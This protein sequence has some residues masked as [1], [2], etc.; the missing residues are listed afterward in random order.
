MDQADFKHLDRE[1]MEPAIDAHSY[2]GLRMSVDFRIFERLAIFV[3]G[4]AM[5]KRDHRKASGLWRKETVTV[6]VLPS[7]RD[8]PQAAQAQARMPP[9][10]DTEKVYLQVF[11]DIPKQDLCMLLPGARVRMSKMDRGKIG[12]PMLS[13]LAIAV[14]NIFQNIANDLLKLVAAWQE[15]AALW[16]IASGAVGYGVRSYYG[17]HQ[18]RQAY[19]LNLTRV[20]YFQ[21]LDTNSGVLFRLLDEAEEQECRETILAYYFLWRYAGERGWTARDLDDYIEIDL[22]R[23]CSLKVDFDID[24][25]LIR[26]ERMRIVEKVGD[27]HR[28]QPDCPG[29]ANAGFYLGQLFQV[30]Q[31]GAGRSAR[32]RPNR[33]RH[34]ERSLDSRPHGFDRGF[35]HPQGVRAGSEP[36]GPRQPQHRPAAFRCA[37][38][39]QARR[40]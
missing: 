26:L 3:R 6:P 10:V 23:R 8:D 33:K 7:G 13:G 1:E 22:E 5:Q 15:P 17:Y 18:T 19:S 34:Y 32:F 29:A 11:K 2:W 20:L 16:A 31:P 4:D 39:D 12:L 36:Q 14:W 27:R 37:R 38:A 35:G 25:A 9:S 21:N 28:A 40:P 30:Q 24:D